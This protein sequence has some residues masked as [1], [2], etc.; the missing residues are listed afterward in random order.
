MGLATWTYDQQALSF[1]NG[2]YDEHMFHP[3]LVFADGYLLGA[4]LRPGDVGG[5]T[6]LRPLLAPIVA[7]LRCA[8]PATA[9]ALRANG[10]F[11]SP[12]LPSSTG[13]S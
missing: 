1:F 10:A 12:A 13:T 9:L 2:H 4:R 7:Q 3:L 11:C 5:A 8:F 6:H